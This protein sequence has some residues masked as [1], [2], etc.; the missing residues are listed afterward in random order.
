MS[1]GYTSSSMSATE[2]RIARLLGR[3]LS[4]R[5][6]GH[7]RRPSQAHQWS[8]GPVTFGAFF[9]GSGPTSTEATG[10][11]SDDT[12]IVSLSTLATESPDDSTE[13][14]S[15]LRTKLSS[16]DVLNLTLYVDSSETSSPSSQTNTT[17]PCG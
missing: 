10:T 9:T 17:P 8:T 14:F 11:S 7:G 15:D 12:R 13:R 4:S 16:A 3:R 6:L 1:N 2:R 5:F